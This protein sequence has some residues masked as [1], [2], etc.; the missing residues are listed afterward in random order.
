MKQMFQYNAWFLLK[1]IAILNI[2]YDTP[3]LI[4]V[5]LVTR[6]S[7]FQM[8]SSIGGTLGLFTGISVITLAEIVYWIATFI[9]KPFLQTNVTQGINNNAPVIWPTEASTRF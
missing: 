3:Y 5:E 7:I 1:D 4:H 6:T 9:A 8:I 2:Y